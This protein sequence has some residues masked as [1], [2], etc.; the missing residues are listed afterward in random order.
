MKDF[1]PIRF[2]LFICILG[3]GLSGSFAQ[4]T[5]E[6]AEKP[7]KESID[8]RR[9]TQEKEEKW[10][11]EKEKMLLRYEELQK[12]NNALAKQKQALLEEVK[13]AEGRVFAKEKA[14]SDIEEISARIMPFLEEMILDLGNMIQN[15][16]PFL[17]GER[18]ARLEKLKSIMDDPE[19]SVS[20]KFRRVMEAFMVEA[21]Y[22]MTIETWQ[23][24]IDVEGKSMLADIFRLGRLALFYQSLN[25]ENCGF[26]DM[27]KGRWS[28]LSG[29]YNRDIRIA[30]EIA[31]KRRPVE[32]I[33]LPLGRM[34]KP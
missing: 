13:A 22:G 6:R 20:E 8:T 25:R 28:P 5:Q 26:F 32:L 23:E 19:V 2:F 34:V 14:L 12:E 18:S 30:F 15:G 1:L 33:T 7:V 27:G 4:S 9:D 24:T 3:L 29:A 21:E 10:R 17:S 16:L 11:E 31:K